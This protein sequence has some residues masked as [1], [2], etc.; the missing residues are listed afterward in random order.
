[1]KVLASQKK[2]LFLDLLTFVSKRP[3]SF[4]TKKIIL[5]SV[6]ICGISGGSVVFELWC[7]VKWCFVVVVWLLFVVVLQS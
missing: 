3:G 7:V 4:P 6:A 5:F 1:M 2:G